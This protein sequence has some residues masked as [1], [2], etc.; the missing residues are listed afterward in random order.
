MLKI[1]FG[2]ESSLCY[3]SHMQTKPKIVVILG[4]TAVGKS[5]LAVEVAQA[6]AGEVISADSRQVYQGLDLGTGKITA[7]EMRGVPHHLLD[8]V[9][10]DTE[11][12][13]VD[14]QKAAREKVREIISRGHL[15]IVCGGTGLYIDSLVYDTA[16]PEV[17]ANDTLRRE[18]EEQST[19][20]LAQMLAKKDPSRYEGIDTKN[21]VRLIRALEIV[22]AV[23]VVPKLAPPESRYNTL[24]I[25]LTLPKEELA[26]RITQRLQKR[27]EGGMIQEVEKLRATYR[28]EKLLDLGLEYRYTT[29]FLQGKYN[30]EEYISLLSTKIIQYSKRQTT[31]FKRNSDTHWFTPT[32]SQ[33]IH[34]TIS[35]FLKTP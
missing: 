20:Q 12:T 13:V 25:G 7:E 14:W 31:W 21:R 34:E 22:E 2:R 29:D 3:Y 4:P 35:A 10:L 9:D 27:I 30:K 26:R 28:E 11:Y 23:G 15:P 17:P 8:V 24:W 16:F 6:F 1:K 32:D 18:L 5:D 19:A 33:K